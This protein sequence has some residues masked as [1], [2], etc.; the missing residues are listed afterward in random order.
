LTPLHFTLASWVSAA[1]VVATKPEANIAQATPANI[2]PLF[3]MPFI[4]PLLKNPWYDLQSS[5]D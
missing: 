1:D 5:S 4:F 2:N 3:L